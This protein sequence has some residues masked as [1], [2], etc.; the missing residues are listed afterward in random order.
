MD[1]RNGLTAQQIAVLAALSKTL[2]QVRQAKFNSVLSISPK[3]ID[4]A[5]FTHTY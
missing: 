4:P 5:V 2:E 1:I 3:T